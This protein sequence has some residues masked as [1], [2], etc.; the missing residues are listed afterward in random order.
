M[1]VLPTVITFAKVID[2]FF[3]PRWR[4]PGKALEIFDEMRLV[5][6]QFIKIIP[7]K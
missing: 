7:E 6:I 3:K 4:Q 1:Q 2:L 5:V